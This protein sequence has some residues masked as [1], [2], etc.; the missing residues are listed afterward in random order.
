MKHETKLEH[1]KAIPTG[2]LLKPIIAGI[3]LIS[4]SLFFWSIASITSDLSSKKG[5][6]CYIDL[7]NQ[8]EIIFF[9]CLD[10]NGFPVASPFRCFFAIFIPALI[11]YKALKKKSLD[12]TGAISGSHIQL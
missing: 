6:S 5:T 7:N 10:D 9:F 4:T 2:T 11:S 3:L 8:D 12:Y 1:T